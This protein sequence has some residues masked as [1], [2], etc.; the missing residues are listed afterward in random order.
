MWASIVALAFGVGALVA[1]FKGAKPE[2]PWGKP[3]L[4]VLVFGAVSSVVVPQ[5]RLWKEFKP[6]RESYRSIRMMG[7]ALR[8]DLT[9]GANVLI[10]R[11]PIN[12]ELM[13]MEMDSRAGDDTLNHKETVKKKRAA[14]TAA[15]ER[16]LGYEVDVVGFVPPGLKDSYGERGE[17]VQAFNKVLAHYG[18]R[19]LDACISMVGIPG[20]A[21]E[22][23]D[24]EKIAFEKLPPD[25]VLGADMKLRYTPDAV[26]DLLADGAL[27]VVVLHPSRRS[28]K[29]VVITRNN[30]RDLPPAAP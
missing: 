30:L 27:D 28:A 23:Y 10:I 26:N 12:R 22:R 20:S 29:Q 5:T 17:R 19:D 1:Y 7:E 6:G 14:V 15:L 25:I 3:V 4:A 13:S 9:P 8:D 18:D 2:K 21:T 24:P 11:Y 16:G